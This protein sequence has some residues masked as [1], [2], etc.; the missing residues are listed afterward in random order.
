MEGELARQAE[1]LFA[2]RVPS[3]SA[4]ETDATPPDDT[5]ALALELTTR[6]Q[7][8]LWHHV[9]SAENFWETLPEL[10]PG[11]IKRIAAMA[12]ERRWEV[13]FLTKRPG[14]AG[15]PAQVQTQ[16][17]LARHGFALPSVFV[18][19]GSRGRIAAAL[20]LDIVVDDRPENCL[21]VAAESDARAILVWRH[22]QKPLPAA[23]QRLG[24]GVVAS[25]LECL[26]ILAGIEEPAAERA[27]VVE[28]LMRTLRLKGEPA[29]D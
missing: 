7:R 22:G 24:I 3:A 20:S 21:D 4:D 5:P 6:Q 15:A 13:I 16:R 17:W 28:R 18:V 29:V 25:T 23:A 19:S 10:E 12:T 14:S 9:L 1:H 26:D 8:R 27:G 11:T 2:E